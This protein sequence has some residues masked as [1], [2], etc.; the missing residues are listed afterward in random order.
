M[1]LERPRR[2]LPP[3]AL[4]GLALLAGREARAQDLRV[5]IGREGL[6][7]LN[8]R[9]IEFVESPGLGVNRAVLRGGDGSA[10]EGSPREQRREIDPAG[11][12][13]ALTYAWGEVACSFDPG[14]DRLRLAIE[15]V[16]SGPAVLA[17]LG[18]TVAPMKFPRT[19]AGWVPHMPYR[20]FNLGGPTVITADVGEAVVAVCNEDVARP[21][22][23][24]WAGRQSTTQRPLILGTASDWM[25]ALLNPLMARPLFPGGRDRFEISLR[26][27]PGGTPIEK[28]AGD[29]FA[30]FA[31]AHPFRLAWKDRRPIGA[32]H[33]SSSDLKAEK[34]PRGWF[35]DRAA[36]FLS[37][38]GRRAFRE[39][40]LARARETVAILK[41]LGAQGAITW[42]VEGQEYPHAISYLGDPRSLP[43]EMEP[44]ADE[45][46][47]VFSEAGLRT[48]VTLRPQLPVRSAYG[49]G[50][51]QI[52]SAD[53]F[54]TL[55]A[56]LSYAKK[57][58]GC[59]LFYVDSNGDPNVPFPAEIFSRL[60]ARHPDVLLIPEHENPQYYASC[61][62]YRCYGN[63]KQ[64]GTPAE[65]R[66][67]YPE[68]FCCI[69]VAHADPRPDLASLVE[70]VRRGDVLIVN[71][72]YRGP[73]LE[74]VREILRAAGR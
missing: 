60:A 18:M 62:P 51:R 49:E 45:Y 11:R 24:G 63:L 61:A 57:R 72:W 8:Y 48:G 9:G 44:A 15:I 73:G 17:E 64:R 68:A 31:E 39:R 36:D 54:E 58:W 23:L 21:L 70:D 41:D 2:F 50:V 74:T 56:K 20:S 14:P 47:K 71:A 29:L 12:R 6:Q 22:L 1:R 27:A 67:I 5:R 34:N 28:L 43:P 4:A 42:D 3:L 46:F 16:N 53:P 65:V 25:Q 33:L 7:S 13:L 26:F 30:R 40:L 66:R 35:N 10:A 37:D 55:E 52:E 38:E 59:T 69:A 19:P 32:V